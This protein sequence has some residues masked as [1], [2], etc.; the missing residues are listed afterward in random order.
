MNEDDLLT[1][2]A[3]AA[4]TGLTIPAL[5]HYD[6]I[7]LF[8]PA[9]V[10]PDT[11]YRSY[12]PGQVDDARL[13]CRLRAVGVPIGELRAVLGRPPGEVRSALDAHLGRLVAQ[14]REVSQR[15]VAVEEFI[16]RDTVL[17]AAQPVRPVQLRIAVADVPRA[18][19]FYRTAFDLVFNESI[20]SLQFGTYGSDRFFLLTL[21]ERAADAP[22][23]RG[24]RF[25]L[26]VDDVD[27]AHDRALRAGAAEVHPPRD[28]AWKPRTSCVRDADGNTI[29]LSRAH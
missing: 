26:L 27:A 10:D 2:G 18:A 21:E 3:F 22:D 24:T 23:R 19:E 13:I 1:I 5:R 11:G 28:F 16:E 29:D 9:R 6:Q 25:G 17:P 4:A 15:I 7:E 8:R 12:A 20:S 14:L